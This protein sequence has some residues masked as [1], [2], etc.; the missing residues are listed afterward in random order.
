MSLETSVTAVQ[1]VA[2]GIQPESSNTTS[3]PAIQPGVIFPTEPAIVSGSPPSLPLQVPESVGAFSTQQLPFSG[4]LFPPLQIMPPNFPIS[5]VGF[6]GQAFA[7][8]PF[9]LPPPNSF[10]GYALF[11]R[12]F[13]WNVALLH[14][15]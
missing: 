12:E 3:V 14:E 13:S 11:C 5:A 7:N 15:I 9:E 10:P 2:T 8:T 6:Q 1:P 4:P